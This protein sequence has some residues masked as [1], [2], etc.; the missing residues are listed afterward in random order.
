MACERYSTR[1]IEEALAPGGDAELTAHLAVCAECLA[2]LGRQRDLQSRIT[3]S[4]A[5]MVA[6]E[7]SPALLARVRQ[8]IA[9]EETPRRASWMRWAIAGATVSA[10]AGFA[11]W[12]AG[13]AL[14][15]QPVL[16][17][18]PGQA[19][20]GTPPAQRSAK[21]EPAQNSVVPPTGVARKT[22]ANGAKSARQR[23]PRLAQS[24]QVAA[25]QDGVP[26]ANTPASSAPKFNVIVPPGQREA[27]LRLVAA[28]Q[29]G[30]VDVAGL[31]KQPEQQEMKPLEIAPL[32]ITPLDEKTSNGQAEG[33]HK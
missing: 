14:L 8:Q 16:G 4:I 27:V 18:Q 9:A 10:L 1:L 33:D 19:V 15:R 28:M 31:L 3:G 30:R 26:A 5:A 7:P 32:K 25:A 21:N 23:T 2:E 12:F 6:A 24:V 22:G 20:R 11:V 29:S 17:P 13:R